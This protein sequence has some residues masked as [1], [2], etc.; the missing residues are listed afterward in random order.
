LILFVLDTRHFASQIVNFIFTSKLLKKL[1]SAFLTHIRDA[2][3]TLEQSI[4]KV[5]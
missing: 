4:T 2:L 5:V 1:L 3:E